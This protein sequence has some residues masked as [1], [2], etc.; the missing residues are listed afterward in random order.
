MDEIK[1]PGEK[2]NKA[3]K[4]FNKP[5][6]IEIPCLSL[7]FLLKTLK[8]QYKCEEKNTKN[9]LGSLAASFYYDTFLMFKQHSSKKKN[10]KIK[11][12]IIFYMKL[13]KKI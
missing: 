13:L 4:I 3:V 7:Q 5:E 12:C 2:D 9:L 10:L 1:A 8:Y 6:I 11:L